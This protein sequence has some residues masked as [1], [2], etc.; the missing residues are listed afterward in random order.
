LFDQP[1]GPGGFPRGQR[2][3]DRV[4]GQAT[5]LRPRGRAV[6]QGGHP[7]GLFLVQAVAEEI[8]EQVVVAPPPAGRVQR[9]EEQVAALDPLQHLLAVGAA[10]DRVTQLAVQ[11]LQHRRLQQ[12][13]AQVSWLP[14]Q[15]LLGQEVEHVAMAARE[16][17][18]EPGDIG[19]IA[20]RQ[21]RQL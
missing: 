7:V 15:H 13:F 16:G 8:G 11:P 19:V 4:V 10:G 2:V 17:G 1:P 5:G 12:E 6:V 9:D 14:V 21:R 18:H 20:Q 3:V